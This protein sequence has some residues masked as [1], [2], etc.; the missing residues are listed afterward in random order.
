MKYMLLIY[1]P[2]DSWTKDEWTRCTVDSMAI[3]RELAAKGQFLGASPLHPVSTATSVRERNGKRLVTA[4]PFAETSEQLGGFYII[5]VENLDEAIAISGR[6]TPAKKGT[7]EVRPMLRLDGLPREQ[8]S[9]AATELAGTRYLL[10]CYDNEPAWN[11]AGEKARNEARIEAVELAHQIDGKGHYLSASPL[12]S[13]S[14]ATSVRVR[15][16][17]RIVSDGPFAE[18]REVL[19]GYYLVRVSN[20]DDA[21]EIAARHPGVR[22]GTVEVRQV[23]ELA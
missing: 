17:K 23:Y 12:H 5:D 13:V 22:T 18:T 15:D 14:T 19:G 3:C 7:I 21:I 10:L 6:L 1:S 8:L 2:E 9:L 16:G 20:L 11:E 4:G